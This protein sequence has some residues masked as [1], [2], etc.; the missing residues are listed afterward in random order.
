MYVFIL[1]KVKILVNV[2]LKSE[3]NTPPCKKFQPPTLTVSHRLLK[4]ITCILCGFFLL[5]FYWYL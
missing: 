3:N 1:P 5:T 2:K 4:Q